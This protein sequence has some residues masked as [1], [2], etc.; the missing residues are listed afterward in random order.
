MLLCLCLI[1]DPTVQK[2]GKKAK[3]KIIQSFYPVVVQ[4]RSSGNYF[5]LCFV[6]NENNKNLS[7]S[8]NSYRFECFHIQE[9]KKWM[10][11][12]PASFLFKQQSA[13]LLVPS[14]FSH[15]SFLL[16]GY[17]VPAAASFWISLDLWNFPP[18]L[19]IVCH[20]AFCSALFLLRLSIL[21]IALNLSEITHLHFPLCCSIVSQLQ[22][23]IIILII[24][25]FPTA[26]EIW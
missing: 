1:N 16:W 14:S 20:N 9:A 26:L 23:H 12:A 25:L 21:F 10:F 7:R 4:K 19:L 22:T 18:Y 17:L 11:R 8:P 3:A 6:E 15:Y 24:Y 13:S 5:Q 2:P